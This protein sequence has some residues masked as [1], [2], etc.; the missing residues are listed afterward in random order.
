MPDWNESKKT[1]IFSLLQTFIHMART[2]IKICGITTIETALAAVAAGA[3]AIGLAFVEKSP[4]SI[5]VEQ[6]KQ[7][8]ARLPA[9][10]E[11]VGLFVDESVEHVRQVT[12]EMG[13]R[14]VQLHGSETP[15]QIAALAPLS[16]VKAI[17]A[18]SDLLPWAGAA[19]VLIDTPTTGDELLPGLPGGSGQAFDWTTL[20]IPDDAPPIVLA[21]GLT[22]QNVGEAIRIVR[23]YGVDV[24]SGVEHTRG[25]KSTELIAVFCSAVRKADATI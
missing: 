3:D 16:I 23:P 25:V 14:S 9:W 7:I 12:A 1:S 11:P 24:S 21:G 5:T 22:P 18:G 17:P 15:Q 10:V 4:R 13:L 20:N 6:A 19:A 2:R 8:T